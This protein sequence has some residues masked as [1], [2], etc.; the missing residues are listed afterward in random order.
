MPKKD[1][2]YTNTIIYK[3]F[4]KDQT[5]TDVYVGHTTNFIQRKYSHKTACNNLNNNLKIYNTIRCNGGWKNWDMIEIAKY[6][7]K[8]ATE[9]RI[10][11]QEH[12]DNLKACLNSCPPYVNKF[13][14]FC[15]ICNLQCS[16]PRQY[17]EHINCI[18]HIDSKATYETSKSPENPK[19]YSCN[20]CNHYTSN[21]KDFNRHILTQKHIRN[22]SATFSNN[23]ATQKP[24]HHICCNCNKEYRDRSGLWRH[25]KSCLS[26]T[27]SNTE[28]EDKFENKSD[29]DKD[30]DD[31]S[32]K[33]LILLM[34]QQNN[35]VQDALIEMSKQI[36]TTNTTNNNS[37]NNSHNQTTNNS[38]NLQFFLN[39]TCKN[40][41][42]ITDF[43]NSIKLQLSDL[44]SVGELGYV[45]GISNIIVKNLNALDIT[46]RPVHCTDKKRE[47]IYIKDADKWEKD[48]D[49]KKLKKLIRTVAFK[50]Q[51]LFPK[52]KEKYPDYNDS[53]SVHSDQYSK[54]VIESLDD[55]N[56]EKQEKIIKNISKAI[57][58]D[59]LKNKNV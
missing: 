29:D 59:A 2:D 27:F 9:A 22:T 8:D 37:N 20:I 35:K 7:C 18:K 19:K 36:S 28:K 54:I 33:Q 17:N 39:E 5:I 16:G 44:I 14:Y 58:I 55:S 11:E 50:N 31:I 47:T 32:T 51:N 30:D 46:E 52:F 15:S 48:E 4:C 56:P 24:L 25:K 40:A 23:T 53:D 3:I 42:N 43:A 34:L 41:M 45:E 21:L 12:Y 6:N 26:P 13:K 57:T 10:K 49:D 38:F 1:V